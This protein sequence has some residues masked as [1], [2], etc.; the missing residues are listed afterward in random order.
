VRGQHFRS[1]SNGVFKIR[2]G[3]TV[4][5][6]KKAFFVFAMQS[7]PDVSPLDPEEAKQRFIQGTQEYEELMSSHRKAGSSK[8]KNVHGNR[9]TWT[10][11]RGKGASAEKWGTGSYRW[12]TNEADVEKL[13]KPQQD[14]RACVIAGNLTGALDAWDRTYGDLG[15]LL[16]ILEE[17]RSREV[18]FALVLQLYCVFAFTFAVALCSRTYPRA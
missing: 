5:E 12:T 18:A 16:F 3:A 4:D 14:V 7:H 6:I 11:T 17:C 1:F 2:K 10:T 13:T 9:T 8:A 15:L